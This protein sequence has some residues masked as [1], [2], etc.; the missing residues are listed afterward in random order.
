MR[1]AWASLTAMT[2]HV[3]RPSASSARTR[4]R[5]GGVSSV[6]PMRRSRTRARAW[7]MSITRSAP[8]SRVTCGRRR[9]HAAPWAAEA[10]ASS[11]WRAWTSAPTS[12]ARAAAVSSWGE[13]G[14][15][16]HSATSAPPAMSARTRLAVSA[17]TCR[18]AATAIP[19][20]GRS[21]AR[22]AGMER[23]TGIWASAHSMRARPAG[24]REGSA[25]SEVLTG[26]ADPLPALVAVVVGLVRA[27]DRHADVGG[28]L[29]REL[30]ELHPEAVEVQARDL[31]VEVLGQ[32]VD[33]LVVLVVLGEQLDLGDRLVGERVGHHERRV[34]G[35]VAQVEQAP[36]GQDD[37]AVAVGE[38]P[39]VDLR[40]DRHAPDAVGLLEA[41]DVDLVVEVADVADDGLVLH[42]CNVG[43][44]DDVLVAGGGDEDVGGLDDVLERGH[45][46]ALHRGLQGADRVDLGDD[47]AGALAAQRLRAALADVAVAEDDGDLAADHDV[48]RAVDAIDERVPAAVE[49]V[50]L[51]LGDGVVDVDRREEQLAL[52]G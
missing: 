12:S 44:R 28:L 21:S 36:L 27:L 19:S 22:G 20:S 42:A 46:V 3:R 26:M 15:A 16:A 17:V 51:R 13:R 9:A 50:E 38:D 45:L 24:A 29:G 43:G 40:L 47:D 10:S 6:P 2:G 34:A 32:D 48:G 49:V 7:C 31:L 23:R 35:R 39:L 52:L 41:G 8:S 5:P 1:S 18:H 4:S 33:L 14:V 37:D 30:G 11:P 25:M